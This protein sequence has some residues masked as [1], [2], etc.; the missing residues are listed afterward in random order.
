MRPSSLQLIKQVLSFHRRRLRSQLKP[1]GQNFPP[2][3]METCQALVRKKL[4]SAL[5]LIVKKSLDFAEATDCFRGKCHLTL[6]P[7]TEEFHVC[8]LQPPVF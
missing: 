8:L 6:L 3:R 4:C 5:I 7:S 1:F 2:E